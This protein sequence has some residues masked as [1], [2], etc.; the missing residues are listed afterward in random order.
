MARLLS[1]GDQGKVPT[2]YL[3]AF[4]KGIVY[5]SN[6]IMHLYLYFLGFILQMG[7]SEKATG[8]YWRAKRI[9]KDASEF[10]ASLD[11]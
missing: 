2:P 1:H 7:T 3:V 10:V 5:H 8:V 6:Q 9:L 4:L 11:L